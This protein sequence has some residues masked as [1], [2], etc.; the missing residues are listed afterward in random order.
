MRRVYGLGASPVSASPEA[1]GSLKSG[2]TGELEKA[3]REE[4]DGDENEP[5]VD[6]MNEIEREA[7]E[8]YQWSQELS[9][10]DI[11]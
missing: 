9:F 1:N 5:G 10:E 11:R 8:L 2:R 6:E 3:V 7:D 4:E